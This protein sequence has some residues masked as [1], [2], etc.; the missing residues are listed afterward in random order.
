MLENLSPYAL[1]CA[2]KPKPTPTLVTA[3]DLYSQ[4]QSAAKAAA[5]PAPSTDTQQREEPKPAVSSPAS[6]PFSVPNQRTHYIAGIR[7]RHSAAVR[8]APMQP[9]ALT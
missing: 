1:L 3:Y 9:S 5:A 4:A 7:S 2:C 8:S 6:L